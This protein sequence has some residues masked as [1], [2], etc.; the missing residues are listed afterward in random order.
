MAD[1]QA[2]KKIRESNIELLRIIAMFLIVLSHCIPFNLS[3]SSPYY[4]DVRQCS[5]SISNIVLALFS[6]SGQIG[7]AI[8]LICSCW[9]LT[10]SR[11]VKSEK[12]INMLADT[13]FIC[14]LFY[15]IFK[16]CGVEIGAA[17]TIKSLFPITVSSYWFI[18][19]YLVFYLIHPI[20]NLIINGLN[21]RQLFITVL[22]GSILYL[23]INT[24]L[25]EKVYEC[26]NLIRF[27]VV[28][29]FIAY[30]KKY[31]P[32]FMNNIRLNKLILGFS[33]IAL[34]LLIIV[35]NF[36]GLRISLL[37]GQLLHWAQYNNPIIVLMA[38]SLFNLFRSINIKSGFINTISATTL[39]IYIIHSNALVNAFVK[40]SIW[41][42]IFEN[43]ANSH[44]YVVIW[45][46]VYTLATFLASLLIALLYK[47][48][49]RKLIVKFSRWIN[50]KGKKICNK[51]VD[52]CVDIKE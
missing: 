24:L 37:K 50:E 22:V 39:L 42:Y 43:I 11:S 19:C 32:S 23:F 51:F 13:W 8:F 44:E 20:I 36:L 2:G 1:K 15:A 9:F 4:I 52:F 18:T 49:L 45:S 41:K 25:Y 12:I 46:V 30:L 48:T 5:E 7:N 31:M 3:L 6:Y 16:L 17:T 33:V 38:V 35:T 10:E 27:T 47:S 26:S 40:P 29:L 28:Y 34:L 14:L 21:K